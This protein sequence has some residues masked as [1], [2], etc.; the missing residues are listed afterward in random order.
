MFY[1]FNICVKWFVYVS[2][3]R[4][5]TWLM[6]QVIVKSPK[7]H[8]WANI[9]ASAVFEYVKC[10][11]NNPHDNHQAADQVCLSRQEIKRKRTFWPIKR[12][13]AYMWC[14]IYCFPVKQMCMPVLCTC[15]ISQLKRCRTCWTLIM[16]LAKVHISPITF[17]A[18]HNSLVSESVRW[19]S[20]YTEIFP[21]LNVTAARVHF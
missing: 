16:C 10:I 21:C 13:P 9:Y 11:K 14:I 6:L 19:R 17:L 20:K 12:T 18:E 4:V 3:A 5:L 7:E 8:K 1:Y 2:K 15:R